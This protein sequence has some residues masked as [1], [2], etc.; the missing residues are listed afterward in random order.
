[1]A[2]VVNV[3]IFFSW[4]VLSKSHYR[5]YFLGKGGHRQSRKLG[6]QNNPSLKQVKFQKSFCFL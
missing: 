2:L 6:L 1:M 4:N 5:V 3:P